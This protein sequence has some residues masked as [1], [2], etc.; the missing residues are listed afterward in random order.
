L[1]AR[2]AEGRFKMPE[3]EPNVE[4]EVMAAEDEGNDDVR[5]KY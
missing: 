3:S 2:N 1:T 4:E 5:D